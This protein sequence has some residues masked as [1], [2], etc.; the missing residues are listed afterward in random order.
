MPTA[1]EGRL[2]VDVHEVEVVVED[3]RGDAVHEHGDA[4]TFRGRL[5]RALPEHGVGEEMRGDLVAAGVALPFPAGIRRVAPA[6]GVGELEALP[7]EG[8]RR[9]AGVGVDGLETLQRGE[10]LPRPCLRLRFVRDREA[11]RLAREPV[12]RPTAVVVGV[13]HLAGRDVAGL[14]E[15][16]FG[17]EAVTHVARPDLLPDPR[18]LLRER[19]AAITDFLETGAGEDPHAPVGVDR[20]V[21]DMIV[22]E[23]AP[24]GVVAELRRGHLGA[25]GRRGPHG[26]RAVALEERAARRAEPGAAV[27][28]HDLG[29]IG[30]RHELLQR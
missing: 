8:P 12:A 29:D 19:P 1:P 18:R 23:P 11:Q 28:R 5:G 13:D 7:L 27:D 17:G 3:V 6:V 15:P 21:H 26:R 25:G 16:S 14:E 2:A 20:E 24:R 10:G 9:E 4:A 30:P 22:R